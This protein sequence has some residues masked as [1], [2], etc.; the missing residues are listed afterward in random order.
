M[1]ELFTAKRR[2][3][4]VEVV[5]S[6]TELLEIAHAI[7][8]S[9]WASPDRHRLALDALALSVQRVRD[10][11]LIETHCRERWRQVGLVPYPY[12]LATCR[13]VID[14]M[15]GRAILADEVGLGKTIEAGMILKE[16]MLRGLVRRA[17]ILVPASLTWQWQ[18]EL[19]EKFD[20]P[21]VRQRTEYDWERCSV[22]VA[23]LDTAKRAPHGDIVQSIDYDLLIVDEAH[24]LKNARTANW[25]FVSGIRRKYCV[26]LTATPVQNDLRELYNLVTLLLPGM[27]GTYQQFQNRF[28]LDKRTPRN[29]RVLRDMLR[30]C[31]VRNER[32][33][34][35]IEL[36]PRRA[37][38]V[39]VHL[40]AKERQ[41]YDAVTTFVREQYRKLDIG[42]AG[43]LPLIT[44]Q[45][46]LCSSAPAAM[47]TLETLYYRT[48]RSDLRAEIAQLL[49]LGNE[50]IDINS[51]CDELLKLIAASE[52]EEKFIVFTEY[53]MSQRYIR[54]RLE[55]AGISSLGFDGS[56]SASR[57]EWM[58]HLFRHGAKV[59]VSTESGGEGLNFQFCRNVVNF[60]LPW[61]PM[62]MEQRI[63][64]V[65][66]LGQTRE[67]HIYNMA[68]KDTIEEYILALLH[69]KLNMF[70]AIVGDLEVVLTRL[71]MNRSF[72]QAIA[73]IVLDTTDNTQ[74]ARRIDE[75]GDKINAAREEAQTRTADIL[76]RILW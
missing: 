58:R 2:A 43:A 67:V 36:P 20:I 10:G 34:D 39:P 65:H 22:V 70:H 51:K 52:P 59:L 46:E 44:L 50:V 31:V 17:L 49:A 71:K 42:L 4:A 33:P 60:D 13:R 73:D 21:A 62:R 25:R 29:P 75:L 53:R 74:L 1:K 32:G 16:Y 19:R 23:S 7:E 30:A 69:E 48:E 6:D 47:S 63:G 57:K 68:T 11:L 41:F 37:F 9:R 8:Q 3:G 54:W 28:M 35:T 14:D 64:R 56:M 40:T 72:E 66:R 15:R 55:Q 61:N 18:L 45:R 26:L 76:E 24:R 27:L 5:V 12:Q 38:A